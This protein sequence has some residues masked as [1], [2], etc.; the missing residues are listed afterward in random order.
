MPGSVTVRWQ[1]GPVHVDDI[2]Y[3]LPEA[4]IAQT[5]V[6]PRDSARL[7]TWFDGTVAHRSVG[8]LP[9]ILRSGDLLVVNETR[10][11]PARLKL[12]KPTGGA[13]E[14]LLLECIDEEQA[15]WT[16][17][18]R[19]S[20]KLPFGTVLDLSETAK[21]RIDARRDEQRIVSLIDG[22]G[23]PL[24][25]EATVA[26]VNQAGEM[27]LPPYIRTALSDPDRYQTVY[28]RRAA[29]AAAPTA[30]LHFT[31]E[32]LARLAER[33][34]AKATVELV[35]G[36]DTFKPVTEDDPTQHKI[37]TESYRVPVE[38]WEQ[39]L[40]TKAAGGRVVAVGTT[41]TRALESVARTGELAGR[42]NLFIHGEHQYAVVDV[43]MTNFHLPRTTLLLLVGAFVG[44]V[45]RDLYR[46]ALA[47][48]YRFLSFGDAMLLQRSEHAAALGGPLG[49]GD[50]THP[51]QETTD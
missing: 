40:A 21:V 42:T 34:V 5:P 30:G 45:W 35:V 8:D 49:A 41:A 46:E 2:D 24:T 1:P 7:L 25:P 38:T 16:A 17:L 43:L 44:P 36:L 13:V 11:M 31:D 15:T 12:R 51:R 27:P 29:S 23:R 50:T 6:E 28:S 19:P 14:V 32:L 3:D 47:A 22:A 20:R 26:E 10:V 9:D 4:A 39:C 33:G 37:H 48:N 18:V